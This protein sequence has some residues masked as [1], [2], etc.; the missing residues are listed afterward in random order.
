MGEVFYRIADQYVSVAWGKPIYVD[1]YE[2]SGDFSESLEVTGEEENLAA[3]LDSHFKGK[4]KT[5]LT[6][7]VQAITGYFQAT[8]GDASGPHVLGR[9][10]V[11]EEELV[12]V[13]LA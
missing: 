10:R 13:G 1:I 11:N 7:L 6:E 4:M 12:D 8:D 3:T 5:G 2:L 9:F